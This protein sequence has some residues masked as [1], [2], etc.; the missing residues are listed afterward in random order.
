M[1]EIEVKARLRDQVAF[2]AAAQRKGIVFG[3]A[4]EQYDTTYE[5]PLDHDHPDW[6]I[7]RIRRQKNVTI[8]TMK[9]AASERP[10]D[11]H[12]HET[13]VGDEAEII[14][15][16]EHLHF[17]KG[18]DIRKRRRT[19]RYNGFELCLDDVQH[20]GTFVEVEKLAADDADVDAIQGELWRLL[21]SLGVHDSDREFKGYSRLMHDYVATH[22]IGNSR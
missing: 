15:M 4:F 8:F 2:L 12:E 1:R 10:R 20:I 22:S 3:D 18:V 5:S 19:A 17:H 16:V 11:N 14:R 13:T 9:Y 7:F 6:S 21:T